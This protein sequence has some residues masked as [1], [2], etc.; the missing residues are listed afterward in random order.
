MIKQAN[1]EIERT[2]AISDERLMAYKSVKQLL[3]NTSQT[4]VEFNSNGA[5][6]D[7]IAKL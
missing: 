3:G 6:A 2:K 5:L 1:L 7:L 4:L